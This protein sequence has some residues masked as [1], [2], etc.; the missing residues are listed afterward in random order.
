MPVGGLFQRDWKN[1]EILRRLEIKGMDSFEYS[2]RRDRRDV[3]EYKAVMLVSRRLK[4]YRT[5]KQRD[6]LSAVEV[7][8]T[9]LQ[10]RLAWVDTPWIKGMTYSE[11][12]DI[13]FDPTNATKIPKSRHLLLN[14]YPRGS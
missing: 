2:R 11:E 1:L 12:Q 3:G 14:L 7:E 10:K 13:K 8:E 4:M 9:S 5:R 6:I